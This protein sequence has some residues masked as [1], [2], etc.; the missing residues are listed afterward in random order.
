MLDSLQFIGY[1]VCDKGEDMKT[2]NQQQA[3]ESFI[4]Y[5]QKNI[6]L[7]DAIK[8]KLDNHLGIDPD[9]VNFGNV[10]DAQHVY[11]WE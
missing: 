11:G 6:K 8:G 10:G 5:I 1:D 9:N 4:F 7:C 2:D 3:L